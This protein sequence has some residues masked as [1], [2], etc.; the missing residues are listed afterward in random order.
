MF[1]GQS[2]VSE[3]T[4]HYPL[5]SIHPGQEA[6]IQQAVRGQKLCG[7]GKIPVMVFRHHIIKG[8]Y[9]LSHSGHARKFYLNLANNRALEYLETSLALPEDKKTSQPWMAIIKVQEDKTSTSRRYLVFQNLG[10]PEVEL[11]TPEEAD[12]KIE[13]GKSIACRG[14]LV[15]SV[16]DYLDKTKTSTSHREEVVQATL[17]HFY[18]RYL[19]GIGDSN[20]RNIIVRRDYSPPDQPRSVAGIDMEEIRGSYAPED[21]KKLTILLGNSKK[22]GLPKK[23]FR[24]ILK[25]QIASINTFSPE[26]LIPGDILEQ[27]AQ[28]YQVILTDADR[29]VWK[30]EFQERVN[31]YYKK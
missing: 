20:L 3:E 15:D 9:D 23:P 10:S 21:S 12:T 31:V 25:T 26:D 30:S 4:L 17:Q 18:L 1:V 6:Q 16:A 2:E 19:L 22:K 8:P 27:V 24:E 5:Y 28:F 29:E 7:A 14:S 11:M 13:K